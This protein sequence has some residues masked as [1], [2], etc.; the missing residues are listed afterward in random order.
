MGVYAWEKQ[1]IWCRGQNVCG[2][3]KAHISG[4]CGGHRTTQWELSPPNMQVPGIKLRLGLVARVLAP[5]PHILT[6]PINPHMNKVPHGG[7]TSMP[8]VAHTCKLN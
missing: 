2:Y 3:A 6:D 5:A 8:Y 1:G 7:A 4:Q